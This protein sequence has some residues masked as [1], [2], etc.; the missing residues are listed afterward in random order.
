[1]QEGPKILCFND[2]CQLVFGFSETRIRQIISQKPTEY[3]M[4]ERGNVLEITGAGLV[5][6]INEETQM[7]NISVSNHC[8]KIHVDIFKKAFF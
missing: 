3:K 2:M 5:M 6:K 7:A 8:V 4:V 1:M